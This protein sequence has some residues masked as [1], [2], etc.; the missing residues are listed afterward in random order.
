VLPVSDS[1][2]EIFRTLQHMALIH[3]S[4]GG[5]GFSFSRIRPRDDIVRSTGGRASGPV[6]FMRVFDMATEVVRQG[7]R[8]R[9]ANMG[10]LRADHPDVRDFITAKTKGGKLRNFNISVAVDD[11]FMQ[12]AV[13]GATYPLVNP[14]TGERAGDADAREMLDLI[15]NAAWEC[16]D[17]GLV[18]LDRIN[19]A[20]PL[21]QLGPMESTNPC[22]EQPLLP[23]EACVLGSI[24]LLR[25]LRDKEINWE[26]LADTVRAAVR[27]LDDVVE[28]QRYPLP[29]VESVTRANRKIGLG[30]MG[31]ADMLIA[32]GVPYASDEALAVG[33]R[34]MKFIAGE[35][36]RA[37][38][39]L[40]EE[41]GTFQNFSGSLWD[42]SGLGPVR[43]ATVTTVAPTGT[44]SIIAECR[45]GSSPSSPLPSGAGCSTAGSSP[46]NTCCSPPR[47]NAA[48]S[49]AASS[50][51]RSRAK[52]PLRKSRACP[53]T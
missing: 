37:S 44:I 3:Q 46:R 25:M 22:G 49:T 8:R 9:G 17:P 21:P 34:V 7:G 51:R 2:D 30:V 33:G 11:A 35:G 13:K 12:A 23:Y 10:I 16:G 20:N 18:F 50:C 31:F 15:A 28:V 43:N 41:R 47:R 14:R 1:I 27:F 6:S 19:A 5:T 45:A 42:T 36:R 32:M 26:K 29:E 39:K 38:A 52:G 48:G 24:N 53:T 40:A 4:G